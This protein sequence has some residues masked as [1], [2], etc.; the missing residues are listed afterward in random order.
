[1]IPLADATRRAGHAVAWA[2]SPQFCDPLSRAGFAAMGP[3][4]DWAQAHVEYRRRYRDEASLAPEER[5]RLMFPK[6]FGEVAATA[7][8]P[9]LLDATT[10]FRPDLIVHDAAEFASAIVAEQLDIP[11]VTHSFGAL[12][13]R[14]LVD[15]ASREVATLWESTGLEPRPFGGS[16]D[17]LYLDIYPP[18]MQP[19][20]L[21]HVPKRQALKPV[22]VNAFAGEELSEQVRRISGPIVYV[23]FGTVF[24]AAEV[25]APVIEAIRTLDATVVVTVGPAGDPAA[26][27][28]LPP[29]VVVERYIPQ[30]LLLD[31]CALVVSHAGSGTFLSALGHGI[32]QLCLPQ[33]ADQFINSAACARTGAG[34]QLLPD[35]VTVEAVRTALD[36]LLHD[37]EFTLRAAD[38]AATIAAM[39]SPDEV[40][41]VIVQLV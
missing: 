8:L 29:N 22:A 19:A 16:Y 15:A 28:P 40:A 24:N 25:F 36:L 2:T 26:L 31:Q 17:H 27:G 18:G 39:P 12:V 33:A 1:M 20:P 21:T 3:G 13:P 6:L 9:G 41:N 38:G 32:P 35:E 34:L 10:Q 14:D 5:R 7:M 4:I 11:H 37:A 30:S 23:T